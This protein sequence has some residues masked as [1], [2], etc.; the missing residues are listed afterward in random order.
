M[1]I[2]LWGKPTAGKSIPF[3]N[4]ITGTACSLK[5]RDCG[6]LIPYVEQVFY[7]ADDII[8]DL[9]KILSVYNG[10]EILQIQGGEALIYPEIVKL[11]KYAIGE[12]RFTRV[13]FATNGIG[14]VT[15]EL[16][17]VIKDTPKLQVRISEYSPYIVPR[18]FIEALER[19]NIPFSKYTFQTYTGEWYDMGGIDMQRETDDQIVSE[20]FQN[21]LFNIC[22]T[23]E[24]GII[25]RCARSTVARQVFPLS[26]RLDDYINIRK[27]K[28]WQKQ[29]IFEYF[30]NKKCMEACYYCNG[31]SGGKVPA[32][33]QL[34]LMNDA[35]Y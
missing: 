16:I 17:D 13:L 15:P 26:D 3:L 34:K 20:R 9:K 27:L 23:L 5:C 6:N 30:E 1:A 29:K 25:G 24:N 19:D 12:D 8:K 28:P 22:A 4:A 14:P 31:T 33:I 11:L 7:Q 32:A 21:C 18:K 35:D 10:I 2:N